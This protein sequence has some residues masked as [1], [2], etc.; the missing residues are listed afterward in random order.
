MKLH[1]LI[2]PELELPVENNAVKIEEEQTETDTLKEV[3]ITQLPENVFV[4]S[5][6]KKEIQICK[7]KETCSGNKGKSRN[8]FLN[9]HNK[10]KIYFISYR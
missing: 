3:K 1:N 10:Y 9:D 2:N 7:G 8:H 6:D 5:F 4:F